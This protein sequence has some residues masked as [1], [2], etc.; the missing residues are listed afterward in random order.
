[1]HAK[2]KA[3][4]ELSVHSGRQFGGFPKYPGLQWH[5]GRGPITSH[6]EYGPHGFGWQLPGLG[7]GVGLGDA[8]K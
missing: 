8:V 4:S 2:F 5:T 6:I 1:M 7:G 3:H